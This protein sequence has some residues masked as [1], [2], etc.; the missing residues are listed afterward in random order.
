MREGGSMKYCMMWDREEGRLLERGRKGS[1]NF[2][3]V[4]RPARE[5]QMRGSEPEEEKEIRLMCAFLLIRER[6]AGGTHW[7]SKRKKE[8]ERG[9]KMENVQMCLPQFFSPFATRSFIFCSLSTGLGFC[10]INSVGALGSK[11]SKR[12]NTGFFW[13]FK[14][15]DK[16]YQGEIMKTRWVFFP[17]HGVWEQV[18]KLN[19]VLRL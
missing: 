15:F 6:W 10:S 8:T 3:L 9:T 4:Q 19:F 18:L 14:S 5:A 17:S 2:R 11:H 16:Q 13:N 1:I 7:E 12:G